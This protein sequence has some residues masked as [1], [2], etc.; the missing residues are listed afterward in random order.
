MPNVLLTIAIVVA[1]GVA[2]VVVLAA[3]KP[4]VFQVQRS[5]RI[6]APPEKIFP[7]INDLH[8]FG[9][10]SP[11]E[12][13]DPAMKR[14]FSGPASGTGAAYEWDGDKNVGKGR[15]EIADT[16]PPSKVT[17]NLDML[18]PFAA[19]N[20]VEF[21]L[22]PQGDATDVTWAMQGKTPFIAK[23]VHVFIDMDTMVGGDFATGL[24]N[25]KAAAEKS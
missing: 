15:M 18:K 6:A 4:D 7:L 3:T 9:S 22:V 14:T 2:G 5:I 11:Y 12:K 1:S 20:I 16:S 10:W 17:I 19:S 13:K 24:T 23:V 25:L 21:T 8:N